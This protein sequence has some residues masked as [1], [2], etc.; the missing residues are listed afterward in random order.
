M[1]IHNIIVPFRIALFYTTFLYCW[2]QYTYHIIISLFTWNFH[3]V[4]SIFTLTLLVLLHIFFCKNDTD[5]IFS[6]FYI[7]VLMEWIFLLECHNAVS[8]YRSIGV[9][10]NFYSILP[11]LL[12]GNCHKLAV[13]MTFTVEG[14]RLHAYNQYTIY[15]Q[16]WN[17][18]QY[19][20]KG[21]PF[22]TTC[23]IWT[24]I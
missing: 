19:K 11:Q 2:D 24:T 14:I 23:T 1:D 15:C 4:V 3:I 21:H 17:R 9:N 8:Y 13:F 22:N 20:H 16:R 12:Q 6:L 10:T 7:F 5:V 18:V